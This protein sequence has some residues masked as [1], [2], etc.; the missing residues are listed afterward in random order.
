MGLYDDKANIEAIKKAT[1]EDKI[2]Y[3]GY[4]QGTAQMH[5]ALTHDYD[6]FYGGA[7]HKAVHLAPCFVPNILDTAKIYYNHTFAKF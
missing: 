4:S 2:S 3:V 7:L 5:Y 6:S 1:G